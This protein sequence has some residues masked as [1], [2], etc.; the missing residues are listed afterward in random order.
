[1]KKFL[2]YISAIAFL[3]SCSEKIDFDLN[4]EDNQRLVVDAE[5]TNEAKIQR[6]ELTRT[7]SYYYNQPAPPE[8]NATVSVSGNGRTIPFIETSPGIYETTQP[9]SGVIDQSYTLN[10][11]TTDGETY[12]A[13]SYLKRVASID[14]IA[15]DYSNFWEEYVLYFYGKE[16]AGKGDY[17]MWQVYIDG[18]LDNDTLNEVVFSEDD[19]VDGATIPGLEFYYINPD[20]LQ[21]TSDVT[22]K[23]LSISKEYYDHILASLLETEWRGGPFDGPPAN[24]PS[25]INNGAVGF[26]NT[27]AVSSYS[28][29]L[30]KQ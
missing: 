8:E 25:N 17:Y 6:I 22:V 1:M 30:I 4:D 16:P 7:T 14:S 10:I 12:S 19:F 26:F 5:L 9:D 28:F 15:Y 21:D 20:K 27:S 3:S 11:A 13:S 29:K 23:M 18:Q 24:V 2:I